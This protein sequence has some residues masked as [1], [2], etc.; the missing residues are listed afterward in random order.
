MHIIN[1]ANSEVSAVCSSLWCAESAVLQDSNE[2]VSSENLTASDDRRPESNGLWFRGNSKGIVRESQDYNQHTNSSGPSTVLMATTI[3]RRDC[4]NNSSRNNKLDRPLSIGNLP[5][6]QYYEAD[7]GRCN[8]CAN[9]VDDCDEEFNSC[10]GP[11]ACD[12][13]GCSEV[14][15]DDSDVSESCASTLSS[16]ESSDMDSY[17]SH[18]SEECSSE[19]T[20]KREEPIDD[21]F[22]R[23]EVA[24]LALDV[25]RSAIDANFTSTAFGSRSRTI[26]DDIS[27]PLGNSSQGKPRV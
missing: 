2:S 23:M 26:E 13:S 8:V 16:T 22:A 21:F 3:E 19:N 10:C 1:T 17:S 4:N 7:C 18:A 27:L 25:G 14:S 5:A 9:L 11:I 12:V 20:E 24:P 6:L 15:T